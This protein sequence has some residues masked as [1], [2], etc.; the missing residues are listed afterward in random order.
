MTFSK[1]QGKGSKKLRRKQRIR[2][3]RVR[4]E[5]KDDTAECR[6]RE[7]RK[8]LIDRLAVEDSTYICLLTLGFL[9]LI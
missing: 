5:R 7:M 9:I 3:R 2:N 6:P 1:S 4:K 8:E